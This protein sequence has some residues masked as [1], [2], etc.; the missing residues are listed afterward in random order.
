ME[1]PNIERIEM[2]QGKGQKHIN[3]T[4]GHKKENE[5]NERVKR[6]KQRRNKNEAKQS[7]VSLHSPRYRR[8]YT[9]HPWSLPL[10]AGGGMLG[11]IE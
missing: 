8:K 4:E 7:N 11:K 10:T 1:T 6:Q 9:I 5:T 2:K 3:E